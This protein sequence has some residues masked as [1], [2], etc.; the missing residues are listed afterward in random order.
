M[1]DFIDFLLMLLL[2]L[3]MLMSGL[4]IYLLLNAPELAYLLIATLSASGALG[5]GM[6][7]RHFSRKK[8]LGTYYTLFTATESAHKEL[9]TTIKKLKQPLRRLFIP[10]YPKIK[11]LRKEVQQTLLKIQEIDKTLQKLETNPLK[12]ENIHSLQTSK[13]NYLHHIQQSLQFLQQ[14]NIQIVA[15]K[16]SRNLA[17]IEPTIKETLDELLIEMEA[18]KEF[19]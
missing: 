17:T 19:S 16:H 14:S 15:L 6:W 3:V 10:L 5:V 4:L 9:I 7:I 13:I 1:E 12:Q 18:I 11:N 2:L 8:R